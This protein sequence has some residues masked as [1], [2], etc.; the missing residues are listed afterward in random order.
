MGRQGQPVLVKQGRELAGRR[1]NGENTA[2]VRCGPSQL[3]KKVQIRITGR[4]PNPPRCWIEFWG[5][6]GWKSAM[7]LAIGLQI[8]A[9]SPG[10]VPQSLSQFQ[11]TKRY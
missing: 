10:T 1:R 4:P 7:R 2:I 6:I 11:T 9:N 8:E 3:M 5:L